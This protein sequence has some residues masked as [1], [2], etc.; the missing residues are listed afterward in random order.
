MVECARRRPHAAS[1]HP[2]P[3]REGPGTGFSPDEVGATAQARRYFFFDFLDLLALAAVRAAGF[4]L[5]AA[6]FFLAG[7]AFFLALADFLALFFAADLAELLP[8][9]FS[10]LSMYFLLAPTCV[11]V[12]VA[13]PHSTASRTN[14]HPPKAAMP[15]GEPTGSPHTFF[16]LVSQNRPKGSS[17]E[18]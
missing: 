11:T 10:K 7:A 17:P 6:G 12:T 13:I 1:G 18:T 8:K 16:P 9:A 14:K 3:E 4:F 15:R 2:L 5:A